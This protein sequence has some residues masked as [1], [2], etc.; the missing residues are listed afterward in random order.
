MNQSLAR[1]TAAQRRPLPRTGSTRRDCAK[2]TAPRVVQSRC[3]QVCG[4]DQDKGAEPGPEADRG[5]IERFLTTAAGNAWRAASTI[6]P[7]S[8]PAGPHPAASHRDDSAFAVVHGDG[9]QVRGQA[10][11]TTPKAL[12]QR[13]PAPLDQA[14]TAATKFNSFND[15][16]KATEARQAHDARPGAR[17]EAVHKLKAWPACHPASAMACKSLTLRPFPQL[18]TRAVD[19]LVD[20]P[21]RPA[22]KARPCKPSGPSASL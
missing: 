20:K 12:C 17:S 18:S 13:P 5:R 15:L 21:V 16:S 11:D 19:N 6:E 4:P 22:R 3:G 1:G 8:G 2:A 14:L 10:A 7:A 9:G